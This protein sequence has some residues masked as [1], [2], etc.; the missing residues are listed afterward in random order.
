[1]ITL[2]CYRRLGVV[3]GYEFRRGEATVGIE[4]AMRSRFMV[5]P[6]DVP[7]VDLMLK[8]FTDVTAMKLP[9]GG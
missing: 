4:E 1:M 2:F 6:D 5:N 7:V 9:A 8:A 3:I